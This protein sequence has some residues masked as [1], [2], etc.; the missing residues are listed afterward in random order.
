MLN[1]KLV[2][3]LHARAR[4]QGDRVAMQREID[5]LRNELAGLR[6]GVHEPLIQENTELT[7]QLAA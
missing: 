1:L 2:R 5:R 6:A 7:K 3:T 4:T